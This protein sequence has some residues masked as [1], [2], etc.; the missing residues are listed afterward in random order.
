MLKRN[1]S[2]VKDT[3]SKIWKLCSILKINMQLAEA[4]TDTPVADPALEQL[5]K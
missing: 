2:I 5:K 4:K 3:L 1:N